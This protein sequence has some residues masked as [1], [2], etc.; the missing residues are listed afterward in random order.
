M[1]SLDRS[2][3]QIES[4]PVATGPIEL[5]DVTSA[6]QRIDPVWEILHPNKQQRVLE[7]LVEKITVSKDNVE[8]RFRANGIEQIVDEL[9]PMGAGS[10]D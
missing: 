7:L 1:N 8:I 10:N 9:E 4:Q 6:L 3:E 2:I 5:A